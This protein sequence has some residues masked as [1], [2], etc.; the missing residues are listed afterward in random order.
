MSTLSSHVEKEKM[1]CLKREKLGLLP[2]VDEDTHDKIF[3]SCFVFWLQQKGILSCFA[4][5]RR[6][7]RWRSW[8][9]EDRMLAA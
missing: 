3:D 1:R 5:W 4:R 9:L 2:A 7:I 6:W 8:R